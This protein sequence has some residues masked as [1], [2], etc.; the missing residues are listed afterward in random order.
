[1]INCG[2]RYMSGIGD[3]L[4]IKFGRGVIIS[5]HQY[6]KRNPNLASISKLWVFVIRI[7]HDFAG[8]EY[9]ETD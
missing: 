8:V 5:Y 9:F 4:V 1:L 2:N 7:Y 6:L 3:N